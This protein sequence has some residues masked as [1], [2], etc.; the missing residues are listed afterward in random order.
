MC[1]PPGLAEAIAQRH[2]VH[3]R[4]RV[5]VEGVARV[6]RHMKPVGDQPGSVVQKERPIDISNVALWNAA[7]GRRVKVAFRV[8]E[9]GRKI[10]VDR[11]TGAEID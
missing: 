2:A 4:G 9:D 6:K 1:S 7:E 11:R 10:R 8:L 3:G 5:V